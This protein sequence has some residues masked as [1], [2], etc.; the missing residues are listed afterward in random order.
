MGGM[1][2]KVEP[3]HIFGAI[4]VTIG[5]VVILISVFQ[6]FFGSENILSLMGTELNETEAFVKVF[7]WFFSLLIECVGGYFVASIGMKIIKK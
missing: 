1:E 5:I 3:K 2:L 7:A 6:A 4:L